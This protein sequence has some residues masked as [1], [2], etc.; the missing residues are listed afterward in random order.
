L[1]CGSGSADHVRGHR[2]SGEAGPE[3]E[4]SHTVDA[5]PS[6]L[7]GTGG[8]AA[9]MAAGAEEGPDQVE[10]PL[11]SSES[12]RVAIGGLLVGIFADAVNADTAIVIVAALTAASGIIVA[13][14]MR[15]APAPL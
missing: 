13:N 14:R 12:V 9:G 2:C 8:F 3:R 4:A 1:S 15:E 5:E 7:D 6:V 10:S 11:G